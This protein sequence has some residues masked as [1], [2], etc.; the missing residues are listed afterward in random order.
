MRN[1]SLRQLEA[2]VAV[3]EAGTVSAAADVLRISQPAASKLIRDLE[4]DTGLAL[5]QRDGGR[6]VSTALGMRLYEEV[7]RILG[8]VNQLARAVEAIRREERGQ[9]LIGAMPGLSGPFLTGVLSRFR[10]LHPDVYIEIETRSSQHLAEAVLLRRLDVA[11]LGARGP[12]HSLQVEPLPGRPMVCALP[13]GHRLA[14]KDMLR[15]GDLA[16]EPFIAFGTSGLTRHKVDTAFESEGVRPNT[17]IEASTA[18]NVGEFVAAG[19]GVTVAD[20]LFIQAVAH[21]V[22][23]RPFRPEITFEFEIVRSIRARNSALVAAFVRAV[24]EEAE[25]SLTGA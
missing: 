17:V 21:R 13:K 10:A 23:V 5:F 18:L 3:I 24:H 1:P 15:P 20:P 11:I 25:I 8:G 12:H 9:I 16:G 7:E 4:A 19:F 22:E 6:L 14:A 2:L